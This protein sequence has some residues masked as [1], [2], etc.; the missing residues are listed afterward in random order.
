MKKFVALL[1]CVALMLSLCAVT[2]AAEA[3]NIRIEAENPTEKTVDTEYHPWSWGAEYG[4]L[5]HTGRVAKLD[6]ETGLEYTNAEKTVINF[7]RLDSYTYTVEIAAAGT[8]EL[9]ILGDCDRDI[10]VTY[11]VNGGNAVDGKFMGHTGGNGAGY[12]GIEDFNL[13]EIELVKGTNTLS[14]TLIKQEANVNLWTDAYVLVPV[15]VETEQTA[16]E[17][18]QG[19]AVVDG[20]LDEL[21]K[22]SYAMSVDQSTS[23]W[24][25]NDT[26]ELEATVY[27]LHEGDYLY[28]C[29]VVTG[30]SAIIDTEASGWACD[31]IDV[32]FLTP[33]APAD[34]TR[35][36]IT[37]DAFGQPYDAD[38]KYIGQWENGLNVD[39]SK[40]EKAATRTE[41][42][43]ITEAKIPVPYAS[44]S[45][46][47][48]AINLQLNNIYAYDAASGNGSATPGDGKFGFYGAQFQTAPTTVLLS[49]TKAVAP[50]V[51]DAEILKG[52]AV[53]DGQLDD[54]YEGS[55]CA[56]VDQTTKIWV[57]NDTD[58]LTAEVYFLHDGEYLYICA[59]VTGDSTI[60]DTEASG[61]ACDGIDVW[62]LTTGAPTDATRT[63]ITLDAF[64]QPYDA[65]NKYIGQWENGL[66]VDL[67]KVEKAATRTE[68]GYITEAKIPAPF[69]IDGQ[70]VVA[71]NLQLNNV[72]AY[73]AASGNG[74]AT[75]GDGQFGFYGAQFQ[76]APAILALSETESVAP[77]CEHANTKVEGA[78]D[79][80][81][82][83]AGFTGNTV[84]AD[85]GEQIA[86]GSEIAAPGHQ[87]AEGKCSVCGEADPN[88]SPE[89]GD[90]IGIVL[91]MLVA[92]GTALVALKKKEN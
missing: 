35:T 16:T 22:Y 78:K 3:D 1:L 39:L 69:A 21:Y 66:N 64:G 85:C 75:P 41:N 63:K 53:I 5:D 48:V 59:V 40:V 44:E 17:I 14:F 79:A 71:I 80:T 32:W 84:C 23:I 46:G 62:F 31:G 54:L 9:H 36:K 11:T 60:I 92:S 33:N 34:P 47:T 56:I 50:I 45:E 29:A 87:F 10:D 25:Q 49:E 91:A 7:A 18:L 26:D 55:Y 20:Q 76:T 77:P 2:F 38:N 51:P 4:G 42:G 81:C 68:N 73:D 72:Y 65:D 52:N 19:A 74:S 13:G 83:E 28:V 43:Y 67:S 58:V 8:Y 24:V 27:F 70:S 82:T 12:G 86:A 89:T 88:Y 90:M 57:Q 6:A 37:L 30:D 61:W 15:N